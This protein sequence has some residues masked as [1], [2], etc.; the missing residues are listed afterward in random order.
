[1]N[2]ELKAIKD[3]VDA[4]VGDG[5]DFDSARSLADAYVQANPD[6]FKELADKGIPELVRAVD[7]LRA[8]GLEESQWRVEAW[9]LHRFEPQ[10]IG[11]ASQPTVRIPG[12]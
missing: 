6:E 3:A 12:H 10:N 4:E 2:D 7:A 1:M 5:A 11:G 9:L 8:G